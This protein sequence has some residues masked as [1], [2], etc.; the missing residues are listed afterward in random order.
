MRS[1][2]PSVAIIG[3]GIVGLATAYSL[4]S[5]KK[6][7]GDVIV[8]EKEPKI[9]SHQT[10]H[11]SGVIHSGIYYK[12]GSFK[13]K[14]CV[15]GSVLMKRFCRS[16]NIRF[17]ECGKLIV[18][19]KNSELGKLKN[20]YRRGICNGIA[21][22]KLINAKE[23]RDIEPN[24]RGT[25][26]VH[27]P[28]T[29]I[30]D[31]TDVAAAMSKDAV[32]MGGT[33]KVNSNVVSIYRGPNGMTIATG[34]GEEMMVTALINCAGLYSDRIAI[35]CGERPRLKI[36]PFRG[37][38]YKLKGHSKKLINGLIYPVPNPRLPFLDVHLTP[39][40]HDEVLAGPNAPLAFSREGYSR[41]D[42]R[43]T[44]LFDMVMYKGFRSM[45]MKHFI[46][47][48]NEYYRSFS[49]TA[50]AASLKTLVPNIERQ[51]LVRDGSGVRAQAVAPDGSLLTDFEII[52]NQNTIH[53][54]N[55]PSPAATSSIAIGKYISELLISQPFTKMIKSF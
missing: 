2:R 23:I 26:A 21:G 31:Y 14:F 44:D 24:V 10:S 37:E 43:I 30:V 4:L 3:A 17:R 13:A 6:F 32:A 49:K 38:Y 9:A 12:P 54:L 45:A 40:M 42:F 25:A 36:M 35:M 22:V 39:T 16:H 20:L 19:E 29:A 33:I 50:F 46:T 47:G 53:V 5:N 8:I 52:K 55:S 15:N 7:L 48:L 1:K 41:F 18:A 11:N 51:D 34:D 27:V 28:T